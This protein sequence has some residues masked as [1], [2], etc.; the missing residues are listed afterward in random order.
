MV[1]IRALINGFLCGIRNDFS[2]WK[3]FSYNDVNE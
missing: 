2:T 1:G 3:L